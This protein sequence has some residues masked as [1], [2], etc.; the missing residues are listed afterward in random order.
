MDKNNNQK[1]KLEK[2]SPKITCI[3]DENKEMI[4]DKILKIFE[5]YLENNI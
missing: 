4:D 5:E 3:F 1:I 2:N